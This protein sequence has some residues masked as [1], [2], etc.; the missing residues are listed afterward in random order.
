MLLFNILKA[1]LEID[2]LTNICFLLVC[3]C[4]LRVE[5]LLSLLKKIFEI[6]FILFLNLLLQVL[7]EEYREWVAW[8]RILDTAAAVSLILSRH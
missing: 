6:Y 1:N 3:F 5:V 2:Y 8:S 7:A 4:I